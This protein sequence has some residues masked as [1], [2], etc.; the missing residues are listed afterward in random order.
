MKKAH[1]WMEKPRS[2]HSRIAIILSGS[3]RQKVL[4]MFELLATQEHQ[5]LA[6]QPPETILFPICKLKDTL[7]MYG[8]G[9]PPLMFHKSNQ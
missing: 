7:Y 1:Q 3:T 8:M 5:S 2:K 4:G 9:C 6:S